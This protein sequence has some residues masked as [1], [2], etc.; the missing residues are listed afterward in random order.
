[1]DLNQL[2]FQH[3]ISSMR[4]AITEDGPMRMNLQNVADSL[5]NQIEQFQ[6]ATGAG[7]AATWRLGAAG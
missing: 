5:A 7:A 6:L 1:V 4:A 3:Q 2:Y